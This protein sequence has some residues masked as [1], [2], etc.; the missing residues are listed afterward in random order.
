MRGSGSL[1]TLIPDSAPER[2]LSIAPSASSECFQ[3]VI[4]ECRHVLARQHAQD[5]D[6]LFDLPGKRAAPLAAANVLL[7]ATSRGFGQSPLERVGHKLSH[8][9]ARK[10]GVTHEGRPDGG[11]RMTPP[12]LSR[13]SRARATVHLPAAVLSAADVAKKS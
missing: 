6:G 5:G 8:V 2:S 1:G 13:T 7:E 11:I 12:V 9:A 10:G 3:H 4:I